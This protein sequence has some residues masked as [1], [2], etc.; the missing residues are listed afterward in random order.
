MSNTDDVAGVQCVKHD[1][2]QLCHDVLELLDNAVTFNQRITAVK[3]INAWYGKGP[4]TL[5]VARVKD[6]V[7][8]RAQAE[9]VLAHMLL[10]GYIREDFHFTAYSTIC[11]LLPGE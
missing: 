7:I 3:L 10:N 5:R 4:A 2:T 9:R 6:P 8:T 1:V 11:Y